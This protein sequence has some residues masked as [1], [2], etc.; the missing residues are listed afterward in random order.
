MV[1]A[2]TTMVIDLA[3]GREPQVVTVSFGTETATTSGRVHSLNLLDAPQGRGPSVNIFIKVTRPGSP[4]NVTDFVITAIRKP[5]PAALAP[6]PDAPAL[7]AP[8]ATVT[9]TSVVGEG[10]TPT[11]PSLVIEQQTDTAVVLSLQPPDAEDPLDRTGRRQILLTPRS[12]PASAWPPGETK[13]IIAI[14]PA[15]EGGDKL[16]CYFQ[17]DHPFPDEDSSG[18]GAGGYSDNPAN[19]HT[20]PAVAGDQAAG[21]EPA[22]HAVL[23]A[24]APVLERVPAGKTLTVVGFDDQGDNS[25][26]GAAYPESLALRR[27]QGFAALVQRAYPEKNFHF[28]TSGQADPSPVEGRPSRSWRAELTVPLV[29]LPGPTVGTTTTGTLTRPLTAAVPAVIPPRDEAPPAPPPPSWFR[30]AG[31]KVR[32]VRDTFVAIEVFGKIDYETAAEQAL[33]K[34]DPKIVEL[35]EFKPLGE[36]KADG[37]VD[38]RVVVNVDEAAHAVTVVAQ[39]GADPA[40]KDGLFLTGSLPGADNPAPRNLGRDVLGL[41]ALFTPLLSSVAPPNPLQGDVAALVL[42]PALTAIPFGLAAAK[43][44]KVERAILYGGELAV[45]ERPSGPEVSLLFDIEAAISADIKV[46]STTLLE[47]PEKAPLVVRY[48]AIGLKLGYTPPEPRFQFRPVFDS[49]KGYTVDVSKP[50]AIKAPG[51]LGEILQVL[52]ARLART[53]P[54]TLD[55]DLGMKIDLGVVS[56]DRLAVRVP[57]DDLGKTQLT[58]FGAGVDIPGVLKGHGYL[59]ITDGG[60]TGS[61][62]LTLLPVK[63]RIAAGLSVKHIPAEQG[64]GEATGV[65]A[66]I[67]VSF[68]VA[69]PL[70]TSGL[71]I[72]G[73]IGLFAMHYARDESIIA[74]GSTT[75]ALAWLKATGGN[76]ADVTKWTPKINSWAFGVGALLGTMEGGTLIS[77][78]GMLLL[79]LPGPRILL[80]VKARLIQ[81]KPELKGNAEGNLLA[82][83]DLDVERGTLTIGLVADYTV[84]PVVKL[85][86]PVEAFFNFKKSNDWHLYLGRYDEPVQ[87]TILGVFDGSAYLMLAGDRIPAHGGL[88][89]V[90]GFSIALGVHAV[91]SWGN[92]PIGLY[93]KVAVTVDVAVGFTPFHLAGK[94]KLEGELRLFIVSIGASAQLDLDIARKQLPLQTGQTEHD[95]VTVYTIKG[96]VCGEI[97]LFFFTIK[98]CVDFELTGGDTPP[99]PAPAPLISSV[100]LMSRSPALVAGT[101]TDRPVDAGLGDAVPSLTLPVDPPPLPPGAPP[102]GK[103]R[104]PVVPIDAFPVLVMSAPPIA[105]DPHPETDPA[106]PTKATFF[107]AQLPNPGTPEHGYVQRGDDWFRYDLKSVELLGPTLSEGPKPAVWWQLRPPTEGNVNAALAL[108]S[109]IPT[110]APKAIQDSEALEASITERWGSVCDP[111]AP[112][113]AVLWTFRVQPLGASRPGWTLAGT[114]W[115]DPPDTVRSEPPSLT[116]PVVERWRCGDPVI[117][118][119]RGIVPAR[120]KGVLTPCPEKPL[121]AGSAAADALVIPRSLEAVLSDGRAGLPVSRSDLAQATLVEPDSNPPAPDGGACEAR[122]LT[123]PILDDRMVI[124]FGDQSQTDRVQQ[125]WA[126][127]GFVPGVLGDA[128]QLQTGGFTQARLFMVVRQRLLE[129]GDLIVRVLGAGDKELSCQAVTSAAVVQQIDDLPKEWLDQSKPWAGEV[130]LLAGYCDQE[131]DGQQESVVVVDVGSFPAAER[132]EI[133]VTLLPPND[134]SVIVNEVVVT[135]PG[136]SFT[137]LAVEATSQGEVARRDWDATTIANDQAAVAGA[138]GPDSGDHALLAPAAT[139]QVKATWTAVSAKRDSTG[140]SS[141][142]PEPPSGGAL[143]PVTSSFWFRTDDQA[144]ARLDPWVLV[145]TPADAEDHVFGLDPIRLAFGTSDVLKL[146]ARYGKQLQVRLR[147]ASFRTP[148]TADGAPAHPFPLDPTSTEQLPGTVLSPWEEAIS[149]SL[150]NG[151]ITASGTRK[152]HLSATIPIPLDPLTEYVLDVEQVDLGATGATGPSVLRRTF[153]TSRYG[154]VADYAAAFQAAKPRHRAVDPGPLRDFGAAHLTEP[155]AGTQF[156]DALRAAGLQPQPVPT[157]PGLTVLWDKPSGAAPQPVA[158]LVDGTEPLWRS[159]AVPVKVIDLGPDGL[160]TPHNLGRWEMQD[161]PWLGLEPGTGSVAG[162]DAVVAAPGGQRA[163][164]V[165]SPGC[166]GQRLVLGLHR[167]PFTEDYLDGP[168]ATPSLFLVAD[169]SFTHAPWEEI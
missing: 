168:S 147:A 164:V 90:T 95:E 94:L 150:E 120:V 63:L 111:P 165:L 70:A 12:V 113:A 24:Y 29:A 119:L 116:L 83:L 1:P 160:P 48:K 8:P 10:S 21:W 87:A 45:R 167:S 9:T 159:R 146:Y 32:I 101:A 82:V 42:T 143:T 77:L 135:R 11:S 153:T 158:L 33:K 27:A 22:G 36:N 54:L 60:F 122:V 96:Q 6:G 30:S 156:D 59:Q 46:G 56:V 131:V 124:A 34:G 5:E 106:A 43:L 58:A 25:E 145:T 47:I 15:Y 114:A 52:A 23:V 128:V 133:G 61:L 123:S 69:I 39:V 79:E 72:Y 104:M 155:A 105:D 166:R 139:Y 85:H 136:P 88:P 18:S 76:P 152:R 140:F 93:L 163:L 127:R 149:L 102:D 64:H 38:F 17:A 110:P 16:V 73:F 57:L 134:P 91:I 99:G 157:S 19:T 115:P 35:P 86:L 109:W 84:E 2:Q 50:G 20:T 41:F 62:D 121:P 108:L 53:N 71:G 14:R 107:G 138:L 142:K 130:S 4:Q 118:D 154:T 74:S 92:I 31:V 162:V 78:K 161:R 98:G 129:P 148:S 112:P 169:L 67:D 144:P 55:V 89:E 132:V 80:F 40:D 49:A 117:D 7:P 126:E 65:I 37:L 97:D 26:V 100:T 103:L 44:A 66:T 3:G 141:I 68:P 13:T 137:L 81:P 75:P 51:P 125:R 151:C 28:T